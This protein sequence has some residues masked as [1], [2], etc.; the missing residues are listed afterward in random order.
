MIHL[1]PLLLSLSISKLTFSNGIYC[2]QWQVGRSNV[3]T[4]ELFVL[5][6]IT[7]KVL[8]RF[9][10]IWGTVNYA[11]MGLKSGLNFGSDPRHILYTSGS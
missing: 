3:L 2:A 8:V 4:G 7:Q 5:S 9:H 6:G 1:V 10:Q 11:P